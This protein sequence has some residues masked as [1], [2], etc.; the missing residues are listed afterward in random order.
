M[1]SAVQMK[2]NEWITTVLDLPRETVYSFMDLG[3][4]RSMM[5][6]GIDMDEVA[7]TTSQN[8][9]IQINPTGN[10]KEILGYSCEEYQVVGADFEG[11]I[12][13]TQE[14]AIGFSDAFSN[15]AQGKQTKG[16]DQSWMSMVNGLTLEMDMWDTSK[17][18]PQ[19]IKMFCTEVDETD[20]SISAADYKQSF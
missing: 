15:I 7:A 1:A 3:T 10:A 9:D 18:K 20:F 14:A 5:S 4:T 16:L 6:F 17:R 19:R 11:E 13:V 2:E 8:N 12:W